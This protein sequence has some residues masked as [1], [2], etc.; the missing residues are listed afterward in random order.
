MRWFKPHPDLMP[1][2]LLVVATL[3]VY[4][5]VVGFDFVRTDDWAFVSENRRVLDGLSWSGF[6]WALT[7][8][9]WYWFPL[10]W[11]SLMGDGELGGGAAWSFHLTNLLLHLCNALQR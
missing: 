2:G 8:F 10:T 1:A 6:A 4:A 5:Q 11:L 7:S 9:E 3:G